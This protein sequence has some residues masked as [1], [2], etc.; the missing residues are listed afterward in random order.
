M[1]TMRLVKW[2]G[3]ISE[4]CEN[5]FWVNILEENSDIEE[6][7]ELFFD[8]IK[9][10]DKDLLV[11]GNPIMIEIG[12]YKDKNDKEVDYMKVELIRLPYFTEEQIEKARKEAKILLKELNIQ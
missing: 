8:R 10:S 12:I 4:I 1:N 11:I 6:E 2:N 3:Y 5:S 9:D 7:A